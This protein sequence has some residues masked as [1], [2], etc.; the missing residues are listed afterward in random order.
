MALSSKLSPARIKG[1]FQGI[2]K[3]RVK[4]QQSGR[5]TASKWLY[6]G[7]LIEKLKK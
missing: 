3:Y 2:R 7:S 5:F 4:D 6:I 1:K